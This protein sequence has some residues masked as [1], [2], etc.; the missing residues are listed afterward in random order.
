MP[1][2]RRISTIKIPSPV[3]DPTRIYLTHP[4]DKELVA[5]TEGVSFTGVTL[6]SGFRV[7]SPPEI[8]WGMSWV[9]DGVCLILVEEF[10]NVAQ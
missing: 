3:M 1:I 4:D 8:R 9:S 5:A 2:C 6:P 7:P 10:K